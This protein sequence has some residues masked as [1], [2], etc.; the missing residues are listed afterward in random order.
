MKSLRRLAALV[1]PIVA[2]ISLGAPASATPSATAVMAPVSYIS[3]ETG[4][5]IG[6]KNNTNQSPIYDAILPAHR[7]TDGSPLGWSQAT[8]FYIGPGYCAVYRYWQN[9]AWRPANGYAANA[10]GAAGVGL[11]VWVAQSIAGE[12]TARWAVQ[13]IRAC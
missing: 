7:R 10:P 4:I 5:G 3:N 12:T 1:L 13:S 9:G 6:V 8:A 2:A 11:R